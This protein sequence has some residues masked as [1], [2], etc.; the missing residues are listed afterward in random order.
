M[1]CRCF[2]F[3][4]VSDVKELEKAIW[5]FLHQGKVILQVICAIRKSDSATRE[6]D[7]EVIGL[8]AEVI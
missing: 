3:R 5:I 7:F 8:L 2:Y 1:V 6:N 4:K